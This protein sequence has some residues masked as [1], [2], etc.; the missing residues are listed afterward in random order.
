[1]SSPCPVP[2]AFC[3]P[4]CPG[5]CAPPTAGSTWRS[6]TR[7]EFTVTR[8]PESSQKRRTTLNY[9]SPHV[10]ARFDFFSFS[11]L[12]SIRRACKTWER[13]V[14][15]WAHVFQPLWATS[16][17]QGARFTGEMSTFLQLSNEIL[18]ENS[19]RRLRSFSERVGQ[20]RYNQRQ[21]AG[22]VEGNIFDQNL[23]SKYG[24]LLTLGLFFF[25]SRGVVRN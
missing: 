22:N 23:L 6:R 25:P 17:R 3:P 10:Y 2:V 13:V 11:S 16:F 24:T 20:W 1:M 12:L 5:L 8:H 9:Y 18:R 15:K 14:I 21:K 19:R 4:P 7:H